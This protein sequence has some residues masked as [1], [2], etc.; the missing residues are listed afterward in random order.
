MAELETI[1]VKPLHPTFAAEIG[2][3]DFQNLSEKQFCDILAAMAK[4]STYSFLHISDEES[5]G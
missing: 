2:G 4:V 1:S 3:V 5:V